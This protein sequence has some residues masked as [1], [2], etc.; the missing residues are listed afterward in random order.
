M[1]QYEVMMILDSRRVEDGGDAFA[2][3]VTADIAK[4]GGKVVDLV[5]MGRRAFSY[6]IGKTKAGIYLNMIVELDPSKVDT[7][8]EAYRLNEAVLRHVCFAHDAVA[9]RHRAMVKA[10]KV[11]TLS[12]IL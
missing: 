12:N 9:A 6:P 3:T 11:P 2:V 7:H 8:L 1:K 10:G 4:L 5:N